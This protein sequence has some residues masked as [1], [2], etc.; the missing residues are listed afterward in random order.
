MKKR[1]L[2]RHGNRQIVSM[3]MLRQGG[4]CFYC[5]K[6]ILIHAEERYRLKATLDHKTPLSMGGEPFGANV[7]AACYL[8]NLQKAMLDAETFMV[9]RHDHAKRKELIREGHRRSEAQSQQ[10]RDENRHRIKAAQRESLV[11]LQVDLREVVTSTD[12]SLMRAWRMET[13]RRLK[14]GAQWVQ[15]PPPVPNTSICRFCATSPIGRGT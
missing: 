15:S 5:R 2:R 13:Q 12:D 7:V 9:V 8:C 6:P 4:C 14:S 10:E 3:L 1:R 11:C